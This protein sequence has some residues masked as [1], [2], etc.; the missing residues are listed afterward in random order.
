V[1]RRFSFFGPLVLLA[2]VAAAAALSACGASGGLVQPASTAVPFTT[3]TV[4][5]SDPTKNQV[6][7]FAPSPGPNSV[8]ANPL[9]GTVTQLNGPQAMAFDG[10]HNL[11]ISNFNA[12]AQPPASILV[13]SVGTY[14]NNTPPTITISGSSTQMNTISGIAVDSSL[15]IY[16]SNCS[17][18]SV[19][20]STGTSSILIFATNSKGNAT[21]T[22]ISGPATGLAGPR[23]LAV[24][25]DGTLWVAN[26]GNGSVT[27]YAA[28][29]TAGNTAPITIIQ[30]TNTGLQAPADV[31]LD[32]NT[33]S[34]LYVS[35][36]T[37][38]GIFVFS[39]LSNG[40]ASPIRVIQGAGTALNRPGG[41]ALSAVDATL[42][43]ANVGASNVL[44]FAPVSGGV[45]GTAGTNVAPEATLTQTFGAVSDVELSI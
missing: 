43:V 32:A 41:L 26:S 10:G 7:L 42:Y 19:N 21:P 27:R 12:S 8:P 36:S 24:G 31:I 17:N 3:G 22:A 38:N 28:P 23:G 29:I 40:N 15:N 1:I 33:T 2:L 20:C 39:S 16:V 4:F 13:Y 30:G 18:T 14:Q 9:A 35:D 45:P 44:L 37:A 25:P 11:Y 34:N 5:V 6:V